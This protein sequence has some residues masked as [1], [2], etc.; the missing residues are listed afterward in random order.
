MHNLFVGAVLPSAGGGIQHFW[1]KLSK[2]Q[3]ADPCGEPVRSDSQR[4]PTYWILLKERNPV[5]AVVFQI[6]FF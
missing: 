3:D 6:F 4:D 1:Q 2:Q 5:C